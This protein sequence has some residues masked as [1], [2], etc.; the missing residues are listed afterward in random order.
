MQNKMYST[1]ENLPQSCMRL[2]KKLATGIFP[3]MSYGN[4]WSCS[5]LSN[6]WWKE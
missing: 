5:A 4:F 2:L 1:K 3:C 6:D